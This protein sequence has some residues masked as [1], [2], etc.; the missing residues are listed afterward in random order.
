MHVDDPYFL[1]KIYLLNSR[2]SNQY[3]YFL[4]FMQIDKAA[5][6]DEMISEMEENDY[7]F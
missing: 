5:S 3:Y 6:T 1:F 7:S 2:S 4:V